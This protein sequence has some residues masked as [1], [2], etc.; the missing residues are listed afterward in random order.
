MNARH[1]VMLLGAED[2]GGAVLHKMSGNQ[3]EAF[4][5]RS[6]WTDGSH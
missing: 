2:S 1:K 4:P 3:P 6:W 5:N